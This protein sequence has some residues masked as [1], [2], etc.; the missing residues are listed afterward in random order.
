M[1]SIVFMAI[2]LGVLVVI[3]F[4]I[5]ILIAFAYIQIKMME[6]FFE[7]SINGN[8]IAPNIPFSPVDSF[9]PDYAPGEVPLE[10]FTPD[11]TKPIKLKFT[12]NEEGHGVEES[13]G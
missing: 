11:P 9:T 7:D 6:R 1:A 5:L 13:E 10:S 12:E 8:N 2:L 4:A 3:V